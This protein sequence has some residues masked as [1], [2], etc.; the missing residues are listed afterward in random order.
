[1]SVRILLAALV[2]L[3]V[4]MSSP[5]VATETENIGLRILPATTPPMLDGSSAG[6]DLSGGIFCCGDVENQRSQ[7]GTWV[8][9]MY[10]AE[11]LYVLAR[12]VDPTPL[13]NPGQVEGDYGFAGDCLQF[14][15]IVGAG[16][17]GSAD[18][19]RGSHWTCWRGRDGKHVMDVAYGVKF[20]KPGSM[21]DA[22]VKGA[23]QAFQIWNDKLGYNQ[24][25]A[26]PWTLIGPEGWTP[27]A[28]EDIRLTVE[29]NFTVGSGGRL[30]NKDI[31]FPDVTVD[32]V[33]TFMSCPSWGIAHLEKS[34]A[35]VPAPLRLSDRREFKVSLGKD[36]LNVDWTGL[37]K[38]KELLGHKSISFDMPFDGYC[39]LNLF[40][41]DGSV[42]RQLLATA[43]Y[44]KGPHE[45]KWDGLATF[46]WRTPGDPVPPG[47]YT[48]QALVHPGLDLKLV[49]W[50]D[51]AGSAPW[52]GP[53][54]KDNWGGDEGMP[55]AAAVQGDTVLLGW[56][57]AE[58]GKA[59]VACDL[60]GKVQWKNSRQGMAGCMQVAAD[61]AYVYGVNWGE[62]EHTYV[63]R[64]AVANGSYAPWKSSNSPDLTLHE[65]L[66][67]DQKK[68]MPNRVDALAARGGA[69][70]LASTAGNA[71]LVVDGE[72]GAL[73]KVLAV[74]AP[75]ALACTA[76]G[77]LL[78]SS[79]HDGIVSIDVASGKV[80]QFTATKDV[81]GMAVGADGTVYASVRGTTQQ[82]MAFD[83]SGKALRSIGRMGGRPA[84]GKW[85]QN[86]LTN[87]RG[88]AI[89]HKGQLWVTEESSAPKRIS[90]WN[91]ATG[92][93]VK[94]YFGPS[95]Y[96][97][98]GGSICPIDPFIVVGQGCEWR[99]D[100]A[101]GKATCLAV[102]HDQGMENSRFGTV[103]DAAGKEHVYLAV[104]GHWAFSTGP[105]WIYERLGDAQWTLR[106][107]ISYSDAAG[108]DLG[109]SGQG[110]RWDPKTTRTVLWS[111]VNGDGKRDASEITSCDGIVNAS[112]WY[113][114]ITADMSLY[115]GDK[116]YRCTGV[117]AC[118]APIWDLAHGTAMPAAGLGSADGRMVLAGG[119]Y[120]TSYSRMRCFD[121]ASGKQLWWYPDNF[122]GVHGSHNA[123]PPEVGM[124]RGSFN[125]CGSA[126]LPD[127][128]G[129][130]W[131]IATNV[132]EWHL[133][134]EKGFYLS[135]L[136]QG[137]QTRV[138]FPEKAVPGVGLNDVPCG[139][140]G[141]DFG[142]SIAYGRDGKLYLQ[143]GKTG[144]WNVVVE[145]L[146]KVKRLSGGSIT[147]AESDV[148]LA[149]KFKE[150][151]MQANAGIQRLTIT[152]ASPRFSG[153]LAKDFS[154]HKLITYEKGSG[155]QARSSAAWDDT[156]LYLAWE[157]QDKTPWVNGAHSADAMY[158]GG[159][160]VDFQLASNPAAS[161]DRHEPVTGDLRISI[162]S[163]AG[164]DTAVMFRPVADDKSHRTMFSSGVIKEYW[165]D[166][167]V[168][169]DKA[170]IT[171]VKRSDGYTVEAAIPLSDLALKPKAGLSLK[172][173]FGITYG[174][175]AGDRTRLRNYWSNQHTGL[176]D[177][178]V[179]EVK[180]EP[181]NWGELIFAE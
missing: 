132:G 5:S 59:L 23:K 22:Q 141:E 105:V 116:Q 86:G 117:T 73:R 39:S 145:N 18:K 28:G 48:W 43:F 111:D 162:G 108:K 153:D 176:V 7:F 81:W 149:Q 96:G 47:T 56:S 160:T 151:V 46:N 11:N 89:D 49:G 126:T 181:N 75:V 65:L 14:R 61:G 27:K 139:M 40:A 140:G 119:E 91:S 148:A 171:V 1:M 155:T 15:L 53:A 121:I 25:I 98:L 124:I 69:L 157:V 12:F 60:D 87:A 21:K 177:D 95:S 146:D 54:G 125:A 104:A 38:Q 76:S 34:G 84:L 70:F 112:G 24:A 152:K 90:V 150:Q 13:N 77:T 165:M 44:T 30:S 154:G 174:N 71:V 2:F 159:D 33:F 20:D 37:I 144:F 93:F 100:P 142:G 97:A 74:P 167:V 10:D 123:P 179:F 63:Y 161:A 147:I 169:V 92:A 50:A 42:A 41:A 172:G 128:I 80:T 16:A 88:L 163:L 180:L 26:I 113:M 115:S 158:W 45:V 94:E 79:N 130:V 178:V 136:F 6:W 173:D 114:N 72:T 78:V 109:T 58:A 164:K 55:V 32:R 31:F 122:V 120:G 82:V 166:S 107:E 129:N 103:K 19:G 57:G 66:T 135:R 131:V 64:L 168:V 127:P 137:D 17:E 29:P 143:A 35:V 175:Q 106:A 138:N 8:H 83:A 36:G 52:D 101:T 156:T 102:I 170:R 134:T 62:K 110:Q 51:N 9:A 118:G 85:D 133:L 99:L 67:D 4:G 68:S 3:A